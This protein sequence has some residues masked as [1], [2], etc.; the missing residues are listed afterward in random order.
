LRTEDRG[1]PDALKKYPVRANRLPVKGKKI[2]Y[3]G[4]QGI[5]FITPMPH[6]SLS[7][8]ATVSSATGRSDQNYYRTRLPSVLLRRPQRAQRVPV[9]RFSDSLFIRAASLFRGNNS[10]FPG[11]NSLFARVGN[12]AGS[13]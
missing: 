3:S 4:E 12:S 6:G 9:E 7:G 1:F 8:C 10:L 2:P 11:K 5:A 13:R